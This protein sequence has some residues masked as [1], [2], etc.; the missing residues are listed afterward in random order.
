MGLRD[1]ALLEVLYATG[2]RI[3]E[4]CAIKMQDRGFF[5]R[6][7]FSSRKRKK[8]RYVPFG[9]YAYA[10]LQEYIQQV[11]TQITSAKAKAH[12]AIYL[13]IFAVIH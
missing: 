11:R 1:A 3:S 2:I 6:D 10:A 8:D 5:I 12:P 13:L 4:C 9:H 7:D